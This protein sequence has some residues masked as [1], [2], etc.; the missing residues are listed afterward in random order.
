MLVNRGWVYSPDAVTVN[1][2]KWDESAHATITGYVEEFTHGGEGNAHTGRPDTWRRLDGDAVRSSLPY[3]VEPYYI[4]AFA[5][6]PPSATSPARMTMPAIDEGPHRSYAIQW[7]S[8]AAIAVIG[9][10][11]LIWQDR[12]RTMRNS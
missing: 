12:A 4:V 1:L 5:N 3:D 9:V 11:T 6:A 7:F 2:A 10:G 8:F